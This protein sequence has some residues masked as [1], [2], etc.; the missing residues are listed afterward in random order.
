MDK[1]PET[2]K[3]LYKGNWTEPT[4]M[5]QNF[6]GYKIHY[7]RN[8]RLKFFANFVYKTVTEMHTVLVAERTLTS[9][10]IFVTIRNENIIF[11]DDYRIN[12][13]FEVKSPDFHAD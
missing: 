4:D 7:Q 8:V 9:L 10:K 12:L 13:L 11:G 3:I 1:D 2:T 5:Y 6:S